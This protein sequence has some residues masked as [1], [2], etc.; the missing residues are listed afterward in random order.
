MTED[1]E[2]RIALSDTELRE[3]LQ[4][5]ILAPSAD[6]HHRVRFARG[7]GGTL[8]IIATGIAG[9]D[10]QPHRQ[11]LDLLA[12]GAIVENIAL[13]SLEFGR[14][15]QVQWFPDPRRREL[16]ARLHWVAAREPRD[17]LAQA[18]ASR[19]THRG[20]YRRVP[21]PP[22][23]LERM[24]AASASIPGAALVWLDTAASRTAALRAIR[25]AEG[26]RFKRRELHAELFGAIRFDVGWTD[27]AEDG[28]P[29]ATLAVEPPLRAAF[30]QLRRWPLMRALNWVGASQALA[31]RS[32][33]LPA[34]LAPHLGV[35]TSL[36]HPTDRPQ[37]EE[38]GD[39]FRRHDVQAGRAMQRAWLAACAEGFAFQPFAA[40]TALV[41]QRSGA[42]WVDAE[43]QIRLAKIVGGTVP[44]QTRAA[45]F[46]RVGSA[47]PMPCATER[48]PLAQFLNGNGGAS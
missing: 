47:R 17:A 12:S 48:P 40:P 36:S 13:R 39:D 41:R 27:S 44:A 34:M 24:R 45:I 28:L 33:Y 35:I 4:A 20:F 22:S 29:P 25:L 46:F 21:L 15:L 11:L 42:G 19:Q 16:T 43:G 37:R 6:N 8:E 1:S 2:P 14:A 38:G 7:E 3:V 26:E 18:I 31:L 30:T 23:G 9:W 32:A 10:E 5:G